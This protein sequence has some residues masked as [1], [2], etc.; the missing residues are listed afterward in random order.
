MS[1]SPEPIQ[2]LT[3]LPD[4]EMRSVAETGVSTTVQSNLAHLR[5]IKETELE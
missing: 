5:N 2:R 3:D 1:A 4:P